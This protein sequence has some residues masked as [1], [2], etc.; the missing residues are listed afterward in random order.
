M[1]KKQQKLTVEVYYNVFLENLWWWLHDWTVNTVFVFWSSAL[2]LTE[3]S[4]IGGW[5]LFYLLIDNHFLFH[6]I[7]FSLR[8]LSN[9]IVYY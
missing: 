4:F 2:G 6:F 7:S 9:M 1:F 8:Y 5:L 3:S